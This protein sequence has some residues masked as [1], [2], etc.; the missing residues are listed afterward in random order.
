MCFYGNSVL[1]ANR[2]IFSSNSNAD[3]I[4]LTTSQK[5]VSLHTLFPPTPYCDSVL[6]NIWKPG[7]KTEAF[8]LFRKTVIIETEN[9]ALRWWGAL[10]KHFCNRSFKEELKGR[11]PKLTRNLFK[12]TGIS[13]FLFTYQI[14]S[15]KGVLQHAKHTKGAVA[16]KLS[17]KQAKRCLFLESST[18][19]YF[20]Y[21]LSVSWRFTTLE[22]EKKDSLYPKDFISL[23]N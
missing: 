10:A 18:T 2:A 16:C 19:I 11:Y 21:I 1:L 17:A 7:L 22:S 8:C 3:S 5:S 13:Y 20:L 12:V 6:D 9:R 14:D 15:L 4:S 23:K